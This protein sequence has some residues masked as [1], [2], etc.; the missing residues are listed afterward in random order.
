MKAG[1]IV[2]TPA[3]SPVYGDRPAIVT[4]VESQDVWVH[5][6]REELLY[7]PDSLTPLA[8]IEI[9]KRV[10]GTPSGRRFRVCFLRV[11]GATQAQEHHVLVREGSEGE[12]TR[13]MEIRKL[14]FRSLVTEGAWKLAVAGAG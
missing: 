8:T 13:A 7:V 4:K 6:G 2:R 10:Y 9:G 12:E 3:G 14:L 1:D 11:V 5:T